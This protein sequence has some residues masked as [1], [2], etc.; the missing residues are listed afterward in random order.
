MFEKVPTD[1]V[2]EEGY[3][4]GPVGGLDLLHLVGNEAK[5]FIPC[6]LD[7]LF[8]SPITFPHE[9]CA[10]P[11]GIKVGPDASGTPG[12]ETSPAER[13]KGV[14]FDLPEK[15]VFHIGDSA[16]LPKADIAVGGDLLNPGSG[17]LPG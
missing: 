11:V 5:G 7:P 2:T 8:F 14:A 15:T 10:E 13:V 3:S 1:A 6:Y 17:V 12:A 16:A 9:R 4:F